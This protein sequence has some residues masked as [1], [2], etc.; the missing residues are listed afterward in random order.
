[1]RGTKSTRRIGTEIFQ[2]VKG[3][4]ERR[5]L[6]NNISLISTKKDEGEGKQ[7]HA[8]WGHTCITGGTSKVDVADTCAHS[9]RSWCTWSSMNAWG[10]KRS[11]KYKFSQQQQHWSRKQEA[12]TKMI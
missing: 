5:L 3:R 12:E 4:R 9:I 6:V 8:E 2:T 11:C 1:M 10:G 7:K